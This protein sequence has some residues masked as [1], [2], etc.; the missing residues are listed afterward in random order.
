MGRDLGAARLRLLIAAL[1]CA[2]AASV[3]DAHVATYAPHGWAGFDT[4]LAGLLAAAGILYAR[5]VARLWR[6]AGVGRGIHVGDAIRFAL[7]IVVLVA[8]LLSPL[9]ALADRAFAMH[10]LEHELL[11][12]LAA[13]LFVLARPFE[14]WTS[15]LSPEA[16][17]VVTSIARAPGLQ[18][19]WRHLTAPAPATGV[20]AVALW[21][22]H[23]PALFAAALASEPLHVLQHA[24]FFASALAFW[25]AMFGGAR[26]RPGGISIACLFVTMLHTSVLGALLTLAPSPWYIQAAGPRLFGLT[27]LEDQQL[28]GLIMWVPGGL[29]YIVVALSLVGKWLAPPRRLQRS[30]R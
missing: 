28:G 20:H 25:W 4:V 12:V 24:C 2:L 10:M 30:T 13:P 21:T 23:L 27:P 15:A 9:D 14:A 26:R 16:R 17:H 11:M 19:A 6:K 5:G 22:W 8:A 3:C 18:R 7:G 1:P 29:A